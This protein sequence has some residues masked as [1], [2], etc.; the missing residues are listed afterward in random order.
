LGGVSV[1]VSS[2]AWQQ[3]LPHSRKIVLLA[4]A[5][6]ADKAGVCWPSIETLIDKTGSSQATI[7]RSLAALKEGGYLSEKDGKWI[8]SVRKE[9]S[10]RESNSHNE[11]G[12]NKEPSKEPS[13]EPSCR[14]SHL[15]ADLIAQ[16]GSKRPMV[17][18]RWADAERLLFERDERD[19]DEVERLI[20]WCQA[21]EFW[22]AN[23]LSMPKFREQYDRLRKNAKRAQDKQSPGIAQA[24]RFAQKAREAEAEEARV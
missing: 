4:L 5:D 24:H 3:P 22:R 11:N 18:K 10:Q 6:Y 21:D 7:Y 17:T 14:L 20:R 2:W 19:G 1:E 12:S 8:L 9:F 15:L 16:D 13:R 23:I